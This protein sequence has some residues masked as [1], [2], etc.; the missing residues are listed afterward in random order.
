MGR[1]V[2]NL[3][4][5]T[6]PISYRDDFMLHVIRLLYVRICP[7]ICMTIVV[8][9]IAPA[10]PKRLHHLHSPL[11][12]PPPHRPDNRT[13]TG[14]TPQPENRHNPP[15]AN[16]PNDRLRDH[17]TRKRKDV[18]HEVV[19]GDARRCALR[20]EL[21]K[22]GGHQGEDEHGADAEEEVGDHGDG[23]DN[24]FLYRPTVTYQRA[25]PEKGS[26]P[27]VFLHAVFRSEH[28][29]AMVVVAPLLAR[30][31]MHN[32]VYPS[33][34]KDGSEEVADGAGDVEKTHDEG[35]KVVR[36]F[37]ETGLDAYVEGVE[38]AERYASVV[39]GECDRWVAEPS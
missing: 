29:F 26:N 7:Y 4:E 21:G 33:P 31:A 3:S 28:E 22:H 1:D 32:L 18:P 6:L 38:R 17:G 37:G 5:C 27:C 24:A 9:N 10:L 36:V 15:I 16:R 2:Q 35:R 30:L 13:P 20:H 23:P 19:D 39:D 34:P 25:G 12:S 14:Q 11:R 8:Y